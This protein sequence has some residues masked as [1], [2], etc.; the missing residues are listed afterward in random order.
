MAFSRMR[1]TRA[2]LQLTPVLAI[3]ASAFGCALPTED[4]AGSASALHACAVIPV[5]D[6]SPPSVAKASFRNFGNFLLS[7]TS[8]PNHRGHDLFLRQGEEQWL[9]ARLS[10][11]LFDSP[12]KR[13]D[14][15]VY[16]LRGCGTAWEKLGTSQ[17]TNPNEHT[18]VDGVND[19]GGRVYFQ[20]P[21]AKALGLG[22]HRVRFVVKGDVTATELFVEVLTADT[23][24][25]VS[26]VDG[27]LT[28]SELAE[29]GGVLTG[30]MPDANPHA[31]EA[32]QALVKKGYRPMYLTARAERG[33][34][35]TREFLAQRGFPPGIVQTSFSA[36]GLTGPDAATFKAA[37]IARVAGRGF[38]AKLGF[39][40]T[41]TDADAYSTSAIPA[42]GAYFYKFDPSFGSRIDD[43]AQLNGF[44]T[45]PTTCQ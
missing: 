11:G 13:E 20:V 2:L 32:F 4:V 7:A 5:C 27:T 14:V 24:V 17:T 30:S 42:S 45:L 41:S 10:Y 31:A 33:T 15:D 34:E 16:L 18:A 36:L 38:S 29:V 25:F 3:A 40:N 22:R 35:R 1:T 21:A 9:V 8:T 43:Y 12:L 39:G 37:A 28:T 6:A 23:P 19:D 26:D 44:Q